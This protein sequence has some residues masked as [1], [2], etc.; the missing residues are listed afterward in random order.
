M[1]DTTANKPDFTKDYIQHT[2]VKPPETV[3][4]L[5]DEGLGRPLGGAAWLVDP[6]DLAAYGYVEEEYI[7][8]GHANIYTWPSEEPRPLYQVKDAPYTSRILVRKPA[9]QARFSGTVVFESVNNS[10]KISFPGAGWGLCFE[11]ILASGDAWLGYDVQLAGFRTLEEFDPVRYAGLMPGFPNP[12]PPEK[13]G[14][15]GWHPMR[16]AFDRRGMTYAL[17]LPENFNHGL[18]YDMTF[19][20][21]AMAKLPPKGTP[22]EG[23][24]VKHIFGVG[25][26]DYNAYAAAFHPYMR[27]ENG[28]HPYDGYLKFMS[29]AGG[30]INREESVWFHDDPRS[31]FIPDVPNIKV[32]TGGDLRDTLPHPSWAS[33][34][35]MADRDDAEAKIRWYEVPGLAVR[36]CYRK[37]MKPYARRE[38]YD[39]LGIDCSFMDEEWDVPYENRMARHI[40]VCAYRNLKEWVTDGTPPPHAD[41]IKMTVNYPEAEFI[42][43]EHGNQLGGVRNPYVDLPVATYYDDSSIELFS[44]EKLKAL[45][46]SKADYVR[47][48]SEQVNRMVRERWLLPEGAEDL[49][50]QAESFTGFDDN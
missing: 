35:R 12:V 14:K 6:I 28:A 36:Y 8:S 22:F 9:D 30:S 3:R 25:I 4:Q 21:A 26:T 13:R 42:T 29:G 17:E 31:M 48:V 19:Q 18:Q 34:R 45:Y 24:G 41:Y 47:L 37:D 15:L 32:E 50:R 39:K 49:I 5:T 7:I 20:L 33:L 2:V 27:L 16:E 38:D 10:R 40:M 23:Y 1:Q 44:K 43:D 11:N 46:G